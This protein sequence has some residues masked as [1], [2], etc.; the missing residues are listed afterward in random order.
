MEENEAIYIR[1]FNQGYLL[2]RYEPSLLAMVV[3]NVSPAGDYL[4]GF[5]SGKEEY[6]LEQSQTRLDELS[7]LREETKDRDHDLERE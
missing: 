6:E 3:K 2:A 4:Q 1:G 7:R 5:F